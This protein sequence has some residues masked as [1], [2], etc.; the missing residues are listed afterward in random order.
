[1]SHVSESAK[2]DILDTIAEHGK[3]T[4]IPDQEY[5]VDIEVTSSS[6][7]TSYVLGDIEAEFVSK[8][9]LF[10]LRKTITRVRV[11]NS[12]ITSIVLI[13]EY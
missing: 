12:K 9:D 11:V 1:M 8:Y 2:Q 7:R 5:L 4:N 6:I 10:K 13:D 3:I